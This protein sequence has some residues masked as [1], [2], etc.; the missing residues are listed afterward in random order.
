MENRKIK[1]GIIGLGNIANQ[2]AADLLL[3]ED[4]ELTAVA[5]RD[6]SKAEQFA[7][8]F[9]A[10]RIYNSYDLLFEDK[11]VEIIYIATPH[12]S[13]A[14]LSIKAL[15]NGKHVICE[16][17][18]SLSYKDTKLMIEASKKFNRFFMEAFWTRFIPSVQD[19]LQKIN[20]GVIGSINYIKAD[21]A[22]HGSEIENKR[23]FDKDLGGGAL[24]DIGVYPLFL[25]YIL[26]GK[27]KEIIAKAVKHKN[28]IDLQT[29]MILQ[30]E[31]AQS[32]LHASIVSESDM[33][34][35][36][37]GSKGRIE[38]NSPWY[39]A[40]GYSLFINDEKEAVVSLPTLGKGYSHE[41]LEC[42]NCI[43]NN[44]IESE[45]WSHQNS[46]DL[47]KIVEEIKIQIKL[48]F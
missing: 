42:H 21:F 34:A 2:F 9:N 22:F 15:E 23:L 10:S 37:S 45:L 33:K 30:Y 35:S 43:R 14:S 18:M 27:P 24:F 44:Q 28:D 48:P 32:V 8:K 41:I 25:S 6:I 31:S 29:S 5:S 20:S 12:N 47:S 17:P 39:V 11:E 3:V 46:L 4:A 38:L 40:D 1:W 36:I 16:K 19:V 26:L 7:E 13:H